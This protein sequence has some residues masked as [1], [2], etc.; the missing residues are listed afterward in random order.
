VA[1]LFRR[2]GCLAGQSLKLAANLWGEEEV[3]RKGWYFFRSIEKI[4]CIFFDRVESFHMERAIKSWV[5]R[6][7][8]EKMVFVGGP[9]QVGKTTLAVSF[10]PGGT[11]S[12]PCYLNWDHPG[13]RKLLLGGGLPGGDGV[14]VFDEIYKYKGWRNLVKGF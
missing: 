7:L 4:S 2:R 6:D 10:L 1:G 13:T 12:D 3:G 9:R 5:E 11:E 14:V 8:A